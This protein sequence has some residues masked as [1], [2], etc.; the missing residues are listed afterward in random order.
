MLSILS[1]Q[2][3]WV[4][5]SRDDY[6]ADWGTD[7]FYHV[8][9]SVCSNIHAWTSNSLL[10][11]PCERQT[12][13][14]GE[15]V[16]DWAKQ[17][18][19]RA[20]TI[21]KERADLLIQ[22]SHNISSLM[23]ATVVFHPQDNVG[24]ISLNQNV[25]WYMQNQE[26]LNVTDM[27]NIG[28]FGACF[29]IIGLGLAGLYFCGGK[30]R[31]RSDGFALLVATLCLSQ[32]VYELFARCVPCHSLRF[33]MLHEIGHALGLAHSDECLS[34]PSTPCL[35]VMTSTLSSATA[36][37]CFYDDDAT[38]VCAIHNHTTCPQPACAGMLLLYRLPFKLQTLVLLSVLFFRLP[39]CLARL[40]RLLVSSRCFDSDCAQTIG[41]AFSRRR[42]R[43]E[44]FQ[45]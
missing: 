33:V 8:D 27:S 45:K 36:D 22:S 14:I 16:R 31:Q 15:L 9:E 11:K 35:T 20:L 29:F 26:C 21:D 24:V 28:I 2:Y 5:L 32:C 23:L 40:S 39:F 18:G 3:G 38:G 42:A 17:I 19:L 7:I 1:S 44:P 43:I 12:E 34:S 10:E 6:R 30:S 25:C 4:S 13:M 41:T 37:S